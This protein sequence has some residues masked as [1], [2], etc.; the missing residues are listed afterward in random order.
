MMDSGNLVVDSDDSDA[1]DYDAEFCTPTM[2]QRLPL[3]HE[4]LAFMID[5]FGRRM[6]ERAQLA[7][8]VAQRRVEAQEARV[9]ERARVE[10]QEDRAEEQAR[11]GASSEDRRGTDARRFLIRLV[12]VSPSL[13]L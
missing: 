7:T 9:E 12:A 6:R 13:S 3:N 10:A 5:L 11:A 1:S 2:P 8:L 4:E